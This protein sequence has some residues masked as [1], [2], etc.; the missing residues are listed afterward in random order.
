M[1]VDW[2]QAAVQA[3]G[4]LAACALFLG[5]M[6][7]QG[8]LSEAKMDQLMGHLQTKDKAHQEAIDSMMA[9]L[10]DRDAQSREIAKG[11]HDALLDLT[12]E[13]AA[14]RE[15]ICQLREKIGKEC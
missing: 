11:G 1:E 5:F 9:Y 12:K 6:I 15:S 3:G 8:A 2:I 10:K 7:R 13:F 4:T 14:L